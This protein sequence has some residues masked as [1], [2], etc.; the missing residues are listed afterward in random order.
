MSGRVENKIAVVTGGTSGIGLATAKLLAAE[1]AK[2]FVTGRRSPE[3]AAAIEEIGHGAV[4][5]QGNVPAL[6][7][8]TDCSWE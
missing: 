8:L 6:R 7:I 3:L 4:G 1:G 2:V 5:V